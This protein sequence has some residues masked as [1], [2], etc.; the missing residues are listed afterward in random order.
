MNHPQQTLNAFLYQ[1]WRQKQV[2]TYFGLL[3]SGLN[4]MKYLLF[5]S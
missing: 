4:D 3:R 2:F 1:N 5:R